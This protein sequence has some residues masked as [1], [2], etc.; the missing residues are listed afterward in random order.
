MLRTPLGTS[1]EWEPRPPPLCQ[2]SPTPLEQVDPAPH[3]PALKLVPPPR[4][5]VGI[6]EPPLGS[7]TTKPARAASPRGLVSPTTVSAPARRRASTSGVVQV[8][9]DPVGVDFGSP[10]LPL[11]ALGSPCP[12]QCRLPGENGVPMQL[13]GSP[14]L[15]TP[16]LPW[17]HSAGNQGGVQGVALFGGGSRTRK[18]FRNP[19]VSPW[20]PVPILHGLQVAGS[21][22]GWQGGGQDRVMVA[23]GDSGGLQAGG[24]GRGHPPAT[25][26]VGSWG[27]GAGGGRWIS[28][29]G[30]GPSPVGFPQLPVS[31]GRRA[32]EAVGAWGSR[33]A[34]GA[35]GI[36]G[37]GRR[38]PRARLQ[39]TAGGSA[40]GFCSLPTASSAPPYCCQPAWGCS[41]PPPAV[42]QAPRPPPAAWGLPAGLGTWGRSRDGDKGFPAQPGRGRTRVAS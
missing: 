42:L 23:G 8:E 37:L 41:S 9:V 26:P 40:P 35:P 34:V 32:R 28:T 25:V 20:E 3:D 11:F 27:A 17:T 19:R 16:S 7:S 2:P 39:S 5:G 15:R 30:W 29:P 12:P 14:A 6:A 36:R 13:G 4:A 33:G 38:Q 22:G 24:V 31:H 21:W 18:A 10:Q 1:T